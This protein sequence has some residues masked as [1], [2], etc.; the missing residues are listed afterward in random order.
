MIDQHVLIHGDSGTGKESV[1]KMIHGMGANAGRPFASISAG[2]LAPSL[3]EDQL[4]GHVADYPQKGMQARRGSLGEADGGTLFIDEI[5]R[6][7]LDAQMALLRALDSGEYKMLGGEGVKHSRFRFVGAMNGL[8]SALLPDLYNRLV[9]R[10]QMPTLAQRSDDI[11]LIVR[12]LLR[13]LHAKNPGV[14][15]HLLRRQANGGEEVVPPVGFIEELVKRQSF[16]GNVRDLV[17]A[18][19]QMLFETMPAQGGGDVRVRGEVDRDDDP[20]EARGRKL[21]K[22]EIEWAL[23]KYGGNV[24][25]AARQLDVSRQSLYRAMERVGI[26][27]RSG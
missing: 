18:V 5:G 14:T 15:R 3:L 13:Q 7:R 17:G 12:H 1:A 9:K 2:N 24:S 19:D 6:M 20:D 25:A 16:D 10:I 4:F 22:G 26:R 11:P 8:V 27:G 23:G 21:T